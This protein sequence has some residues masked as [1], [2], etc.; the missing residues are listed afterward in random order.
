MK[1]FKYRAMEK[2]GGKIDG[3]YEANCEEDVISMITAN[4]YYPLKI[5]EIIESTK[6]EFKFREEVTTKD[7]SI[8]VDKYIQCLMQVYL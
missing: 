5:E 3:D 2:D 6:I 7:M 8:F 1:K 4:G